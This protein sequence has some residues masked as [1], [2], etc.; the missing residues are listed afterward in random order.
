MAKNK[1][2]RKDAENAKETPV[3]E[4]P[5]FTISADS[6]FGIRCMMSIAAHAEM[7]TPEERVAI[8]GKLR[9]FDL[10]EEAVRTADAE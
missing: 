2:S 4:V 3:L 5:T 10:Y 7:L 1:V 8:K 9:E 6:D